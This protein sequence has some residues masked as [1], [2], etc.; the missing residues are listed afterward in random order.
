MTS[1]PDGPPR[2]NFLIVGAQ[3]SGTSALASFLAQHP[4]IC[5]SPKKELHFFDSPQFNDDDSAAAIEASYHSA[6]PNYCGQPLVGESTPIY[7]FLPQV[8]GRIHRYNPAMKLIVLLRD[9]VARAISNYHMRIT[10]GSEFRPMAQAFLLEGLNLLRKSHRA[11]EKLPPRSYLAR[12]FYS[13]QIA[14][15]LRYFDRDQI[16]I[17]RHDEFVDQR[18]NILQRVYQFLGVQ[19][20]SFIASAASVAAGDYKVATPSYVAFFLRLV[21]AREIHRL[22]KAMNWDLTAWRESN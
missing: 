22:E 11:P 10:R 7:M 3:K 17:L 1:R 4:E 12:G 5:H 6:F 16:L 8:A 15:L 13:R 20:R 2:V 21:F 19:D 9:P 14:N 18:E